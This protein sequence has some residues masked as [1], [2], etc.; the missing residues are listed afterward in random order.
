VN[1]ID[2]LQKQKVVLQQ[3]KTFEESQKNLNRDQQ[4]PQIHPDRAIQIL[5]ERAVSATPRDLTEDQCL[6]RILEDAEKVIQDSLSNRSTGNP[7]RVY[8]LRETRKQLK[9]ARRVKH[10]QESRTSRSLQ[11]PRSKI[12]RNLS[13]E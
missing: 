10:L 7:G 13:K 9:K 6:D 3:T 2:S 5:G 11:E 1:H 12:I 4:F 8:P